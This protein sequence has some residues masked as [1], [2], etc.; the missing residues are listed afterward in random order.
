MSGHDLSRRLFQQRKVPTLLEQVRGHA[1]C[2]SAVTVALS[3]Q[4]PL[5]SRAMNAS[6]LAA[7]PWW[8]PDT[9]DSAGHPRRPAAGRH[10]SD[11]RREE[12]R[13]AADGVGAADAASRDPAQRAGQSRRRG[14]GV[15]AAASGLRDA[16]VVDRRRASS[17][18]ISADRIAARRHRRRAG[19]AHARL[20]AAA[21][22]AAGALR[23]GAPADAGR[24]RHRP[25]RHRLS[26]GGPA[27]HGRHGRA[28]R[29]HDP[30]DG[31]RGLRGA[32]I[33]LP[34]P[35][36]GATEN[37]LLAAV[38]GERHDDDPQRRAR[39]GDRRPGRLPDRD[40]RQDCRPRQPSC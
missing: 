24:R 36:V 18:T 6:L 16:L 29:R 12:R 2:I 26:S 28:R 32:D 7:A 25:A 20:G 8:R 11:Q 27:R 14:T 33:L 37:L 17:V 1:H 21:R 3:T 35:S 4:P 10:L 34:L 9:G 19:G 30:G 31:A 23:R 40:G 22:R 5:S 13:A 15:V 38:A 39:A